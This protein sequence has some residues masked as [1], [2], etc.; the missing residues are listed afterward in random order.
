[1]RSLYTFKQGQYVTIK[2]ELGGQ[3]IRRSYSIC[4]SPMDNELRVAVK[5]VPQ[6]V[7]STYANEHLKKG[8]IL[9]LMPPTGKFYT[10]LNAKNEKNYV[11]FASGSGITPIMSIMKTVLQTEPNSTFTL[12]YGNKNA[13]SVIF[14][15]GIEGLKNKYLE[16]LSVFHI[17]SRETNESEILN[18]RIDSKKCD[19]FCEH[20]IDVNSISDF[21]LCGP[22]EMIF[23]VKE[24]LEKRGVDHKKIHFELFTSSES[25]KAILGN[26]ADT[27][28]NTL[29]EI[30]IKLDGKI[31]TFGLAK[32][33]INILDAALQLGADLPYACKG[34]VC[35][36]CKAKVIEG[37]V[38]MDLNYGLEED[39]IENNY[40]LTCQSHPVSEKVVVDYDV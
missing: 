33:G 36:T 38:K 37:E 29:S 5:K 8:E 21:F 40:I 11:G 16:R 14:K 30:N 23:V 27:G 28:N 10:E 34:G 32:N 26:T 12:F 4:S 18:G 20:F 1:M 9:E 22:E 3:E 31:M 2:I 15:E 35:C 7:F 6:G 25:K 19:E 13:A 17:L 39:E 24:N